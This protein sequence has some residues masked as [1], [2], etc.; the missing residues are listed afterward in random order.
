MQVTGY[1]SQQTRQYGKRTIKNVFGLLV[2]CG[3]FLYLYIS[4]SVEWIHKPKTKLVYSTTSI[5]TS[6]RPY[7]AKTKVLILED[8]EMCQNLLYGGNK[9][10]MESRNPDDTSDVDVLGVMKQG[11]GNFKSKY[12]S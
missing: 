9:S 12:A 2:L 3:T 5:L 8:D 4:T 6:A 1:S 10:D 11:C 7:I